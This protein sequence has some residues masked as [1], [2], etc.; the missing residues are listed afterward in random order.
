MATTFGRVI[1]LIEKLT[2]IGRVAVAG[3]INVGCEASSISAV[4]LSKNED[5]IPSSGA[6]DKRAGDFPALGGLDYFNYRN[7]R[8]KNLIF[9]SHRFLSRIQVRN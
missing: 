1:Q 5:S 6:K 2:R 4:V 8:L 3:R 7:L 9:L